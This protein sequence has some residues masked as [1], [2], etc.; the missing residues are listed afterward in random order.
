MPFLAPYCSSDIVSSPWQHYER[1]A[2]HIRRAYPRLK[3][4]AN[5][6]LGDDA[7]FD[8][9]EMHSYRSPKETFDLRSAI[10]TYEVCVLLIATRMGSFFILLLNLIVTSPKPQ[11]RPVAVTE[12]A[13]MS[14]KEDAT[15]AVAEAGF[16]SSLERNC[17]KVRILADQR[18]RPSSHP[19]AV[20]TCLRPVTG[21][22]GCLRAPAGSQGR[23]RLDARPDPV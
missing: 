7:D 16:M 10:D 22:D 1:F 12:F 15:Q 18:L 17:H 5:C 19:H 9:W 3:L 14:D 21:L 13:A 2:K 11:G 20:S 4:I 23:P 8:T 6:D